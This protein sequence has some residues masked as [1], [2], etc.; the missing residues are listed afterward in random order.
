MNS[1]KQD[2]QDFA[3][4]VLD[5]KATALQAKALIPD[6]HNRVEVASMSSP[7]NLPAS[8]PPLG[9]RS[10]GRPNNTG[11]VG[12][13]VLAPGTAANK[14]R[15]IPG[16]VN[17]VMPTLSATALNHDPFPEVT[18]TTQTWFWVRCETT[19]GATDTHDVIIETSTAGPSKPAGTD[20][21]A[22]GFVDY[23]Y[24][25]S[26]DVDA[27]V[28]SILENRSGG[29]LKVDAFGSLISWAIA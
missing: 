15:V 19:Y 24:I 12:H 6:Q 21:T 8:V 14:I 5:S 10:G 3:R 18:I 25:G 16:L 1:P 23:H 26:A 20:I 17:S 7:V 2:L 27:G 9:R 28:A 4:G 11:T 22:G 29:D 13:L